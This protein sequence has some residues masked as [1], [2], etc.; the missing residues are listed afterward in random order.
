MLKL[1]WDIFTAIAGDNIEVV[2]VDT[3]EQYTLEEDIISMILLTNESIASFDSK[4]ILI[5]YISDKEFV[6][7]LHHYDCTMVL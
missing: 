6:F 1:G 3:D 2:N 5:W 4:E 7:A